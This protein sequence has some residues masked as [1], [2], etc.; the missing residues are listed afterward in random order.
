MLGHCTCPMYHTYPSHRLLDAPYLLEVQASW[1]AL[2]HAEL[3]YTHHGAGPGGDDCRGG[4]AHSTQTV[5]PG[6][7]V[8]KCHQ[9]LCKISRVSMGTKAST[10]LGSQAS[11][12]E[13][14]RQVWMPLP[15]HEL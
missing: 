2:S 14:H 3:P 15:A 6:S 9:D 13:G 11:M 8:L 12:T 1:V 10:G 4:W 5:S 7:Q